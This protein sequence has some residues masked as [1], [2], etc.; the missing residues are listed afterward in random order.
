M[1]PSIAILVWI[2]LLS[3]LLRFDPAREP[4]TSTAVWVPAI[5]MFIILT[6]LPS[7]WLGGGGTSAVQALEEGNPLDRAVYSLLILLTVVI[8]SRRSFKWNLFFSRN[9]ALTIFIFYCLVSVIWSDFPFIAFKRWIRD[10]GNYLVILVVLS[11]ADPLEAVRSFFRH[12][13]YLLLPLSILLIKYFPQLGKQYSFWTG[14]TEFVGAATS[15]NTLGLM[16]LL[17]GLFFFWDTVARWSK[18]KEKRTKKILRINVAF[19]LMA[20][21]LLSLSN[22]ATSR[23]CLSLGCLIVLAV[24]SNWGRR[25]PTLLKVLVPSCFVVYLILA[26]GFD[27]NGIF[28]SQVGRDPSLT[29][30]TNIWDAVLSTHTNPILGTGYDSFW[31]GDRLNIVWRL[32]GTVN[33]SHNGYLETYLNLGTIGLLL[34]I[35]LLL[36]SYKVI[37]NN[38]VPSPAFASLTLAMWLIALFYNMTEASLTP[39][40]MCLTFLWGAVEVPRTTPVSNSAGHLFPKNFGHGKQNETWSEGRNLAKVKQQ[41]LKY[42]HTI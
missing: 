4:N 6:R 38:L 8:L 12:L 3:A 34:M 20:L 16:C 18:R 39:A 7:Q 10:A 31:L 14:A 1:P 35:G 5:W 17:G 9:L 11:D 28:A 23:V 27:L 15:K 42:R 41:P 36:A 30:R 26:F 2:L 33:E 21:W 32:A 37:C 29:G 19:I 22:S 25:S 24:H 13:Y 40:F